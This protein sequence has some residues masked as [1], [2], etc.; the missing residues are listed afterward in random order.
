MRRG[1]RT[2]PEVVQVVVTGR[3]VEKHSKTP[4]FRRPAPQVLHVSLCCQLGQTQQQKKDIFLV[5][6]PLLDTS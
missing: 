6:E 4:V 3:Q 2:A 5:R 1:A